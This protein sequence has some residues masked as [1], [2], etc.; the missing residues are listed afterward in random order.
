MRMFRKFA[1]FTGVAALTMISAAQSA[2]LDFTITGK[3]VGSGISWQSNSTISTLENVFTAG[4]GDWIFSKLTTTNSQNLANLLT[5][6]EWWNKGPYAGTGL[7]ILVGKTGSY[8]SG[9]GYIVFEDTGTPI[10]TY[11]G[12]LSANHGRPYDATFNP[13]TYMLATSTGMDRLVIGSPVPES[14]TWT[15]MLLGFGGLG[16]AS[17]RRD[18]T[19]HAA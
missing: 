3:D 15:L 7:G 4:Q 18:K 9:G 1:F 19:V 5:T 12:G 14:S 17:Y 10:F 13:G 8:G 6:K 16:V 11:T 2:V